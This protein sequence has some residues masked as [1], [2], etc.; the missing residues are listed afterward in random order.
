MPVSNL[1]SIF[2]V[3]LNIKVDKRKK[4]KIDEL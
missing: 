3:S 2:D 1:G 4:D